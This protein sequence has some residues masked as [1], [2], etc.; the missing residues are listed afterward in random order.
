MITTI[1]LK[2][3]PDS[4]NP[5]AI[6]KD[7]REAFQPLSEFRG[8]GVPKH[9]YLPLPAPSSSVTIGP[10]SIAT[11][12]L[13]LKSPGLTT[14]PCPLPLDLLRWSICLSLY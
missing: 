6:A 4:R 2:R 11:A 14:S 1:P 12:T 8:T 3:T 13:V 9:C 7:F 5:I 10:R